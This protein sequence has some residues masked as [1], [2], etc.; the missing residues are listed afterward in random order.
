MDGRVIKPDLK[1]ALTAWE[2]SQKD[3]RKG[4]ST[5]WKTQVETSSGVT[6]PIWLTAVVDSKIVQRLDNCLGPQ[7]LQ[8]MH[9][10]DYVDDGHGDVKT[11]EYIENTVAKTHFIYRN[12]MGSVGQAD[13]KAQF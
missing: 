13:A 12:Y 10:Q 7:H 4:S 6:V 2:K 8:K 9:F 11:K 5:F 3:A 1:S